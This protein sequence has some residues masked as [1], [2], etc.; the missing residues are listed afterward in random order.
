M[1]PEQ[2]KALLSRTEWHEMVE[3]AL[4]QSMPEYIRRKREEASKLL[5][6]IEERKRNQWN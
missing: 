2:A 4:K 6:E 1:T 3:R 5:Q